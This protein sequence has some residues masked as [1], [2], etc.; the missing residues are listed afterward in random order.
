MLSKNILSSCPSRDT[1]R[2]EIWKLIF[3]DYNIY[4][5]IA[6]FLLNVIRKNI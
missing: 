2:E 4:E 3:Q 1:N 6:I 5:Y